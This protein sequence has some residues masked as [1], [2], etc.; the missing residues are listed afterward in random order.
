MRSNAISVYVTLD[1]GVHV[2]MFWSSSQSDAKLPVFSSQ[3]REIL[4][5]SVYGNGKL[6]S[7]KTED[8]I[9]HVGNVRIDPPEDSH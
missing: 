9:S 3:A 5:G 7:H 2:Q 8:P 6:F 4:V 1:A